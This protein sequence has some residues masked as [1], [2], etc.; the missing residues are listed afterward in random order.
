M[1][2]ILK[3]PAPITV[4]DFPPDTVRTRAGALHFRPG[5]LVEIT[6]SEY[7]HLKGGGMNLEIHTADAK[8]ASQT[9]GTGEPV[10]GGS[11]VDD[12]LLELSV[13]AVRDEVL[14]RKSGMMAEEYA[15]F[16]MR[17]ALIEADG[18]N[19]SSLIH[20]FE[21]EAKHCGV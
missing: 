11:G 7:E 12:K 14:T 5:S 2:V 4:D 13:A 16:I 20:F 8:D 9:G 10:A 19:R 1:K 3:S 18:K 6:Q 21:E 15:D 17:L